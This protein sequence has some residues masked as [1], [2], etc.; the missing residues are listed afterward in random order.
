MHPIRIWQWPN[1]LAL[2]AALIA[3]AWQVVFA[4]TLGLQISATAQIVLGLS[5][6]LTYM[7]DRLFDVTKRP[8]EQLYSTRHRFA[9]R[10]TH[11]LWTVWSGTLTLNIGIA[12]TGLSNKELL[13]GFILLA[14]CLLYTALNQA[15]SHRFFPKEICVALIFVGGVIVFLLPN[16]ALWMPSAALTLL[17]LINCLMIGLK[18]KRVDAALQVKSMARLPSQI[19]LI[20]KL[21]CGGTLFYL[22]PEA[23]LPIGLSLGTLCMIHAYQRRLSTEAYRVLVD[24]ALFAGPVTAWCIL[25]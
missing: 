9:K 6:W 24:C 8:I 11:V 12:L 19:T 5:V 18:E 7:A 1:L 17:C 22:T 3:L 25:A 2:D 13:N 4:N 16:A 15:L 23:A 14:L 20:L 10:H 21:I